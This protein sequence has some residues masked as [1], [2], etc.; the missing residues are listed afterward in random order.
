MGRK[1]TNVGSRLEVP[2]PSGGDSRAYQGKRFRF[3]DGTSVYHSGKHN[4]TKMAEIKMIVNA[5]GL[6]MYIAGILTNLNNWIGIAL[7]VVGFLVAVVM[8]AT[9]YQ[10]YRIVRIERLRTEYEFNQQFPNHKSTFM[11]STDKDLK[12]YW[13]AARIFFAVVLA[14]VLG[15]GL[16]GKETWMVYRVWHPFKLEDILGIVGLVFL[17]IVLSGGLKKVQQWIEPKSEGSVGYAWVIGVASAILL[18]ISW[19]DASVY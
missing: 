1:I 4:R 17:M 14:I 2:V 16:F 9:R 8:L 13:F 5:I 18:V 3:P 11:P 7:G 19:V 12:P 6:T 10:K 15:M